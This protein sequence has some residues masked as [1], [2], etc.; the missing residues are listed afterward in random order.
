MSI[1]FFFLLVKLEIKGIEYTKPPSLKLGTKKWETGDEILV[2][3]YLRN[4]DMRDQ[5]MVPFIY[6]QQGERRQQKKSEEDGLAIVMANRRWEE[7]H[8]LLCDWYPGKKIASCFSNSDIRMSCETMITWCIS[9]V[10]LHDE[11]ALKKTTV[12]YP[13][14]S[15]TDQWWMQFWS[16]QE[17]TRITVSLVRFLWRRKPETLEL[18]FQTVWKITEYVYPGPDPAAML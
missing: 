5:E 7:N 4:W 11:V 8:L 15:L 17:I 14:W 16:Y 6:Q 2:F 18:M 3:L 13:G 1:F 12:I 10:T 9:F